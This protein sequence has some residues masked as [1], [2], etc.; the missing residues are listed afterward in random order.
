MECDEKNTYK[1]A[2]ERSRA[3]ADVFNSRMRKY[4]FK[5]REAER[6]SAS[7]GDSRSEADSKTDTKTRDE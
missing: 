1:N 3:A 5:Y 7:G 2:C 6:D 4:R